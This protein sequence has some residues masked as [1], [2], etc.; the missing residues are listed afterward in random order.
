M[1]GCNQVGR[2]CLT[3]T[4]CS[5]RGLVSRLSRQSVIDRLTFTV[6]DSWKRPA[7]PQLALLLRIGA[8]SQSGH[9]TYAPHI[10]LPGCAGP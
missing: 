9:Q 8:A 7:L 6:D 3:T 1:H 2:E 4:S 10:T 5:A